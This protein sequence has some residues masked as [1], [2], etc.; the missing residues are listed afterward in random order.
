MNVLARITPA[1]FTSRLTSAHCRAARA[2]ASG[3]VMSS[4]TGVT[5]GSVTA[6]GSRAAP[7]T[8][9]APRLTSSRANARPSPRLAPVTRAT[10][11]AICMAPPP[12]RVFVHIKGRRQS[13]VLAPE[14][15]GL[16]GMPSLLIVTRRGL[17]FGYFRPHDLFGFARTEAAPPR[18]ARTKARGPASEMRAA[19]PGRTR[20]ASGNGPSVVDLGQRREQRRHRNDVPA[21][22]WQPSWAPLQARP[23]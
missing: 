21:P 4:A 5:P 2:T 12:L 8:L 23:R 14:P 1:L 20:R 10:D 16:A 17:T 22:N 6:T 13:A 11:P 3:S 7:Y 15:I 18:L 19:G 9:A